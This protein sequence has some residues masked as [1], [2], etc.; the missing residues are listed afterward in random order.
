MRRVDRHTYVMRECE[1]GIVDHQRIDREVA[2][3]KRQNARVVVDGLAASSCIIFL[4]ALE[5]ADANLV[6]VTDN[7]WFLTHAFIRTD[8][9]GRAH[10]YGSES[11]PKPEPED[12][13][14]TIA[15][16]RCEIIRSWLRHN[17]HRLEYLRLSELPHTMMIALLGQCEDAKRWR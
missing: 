11:A 3:I 16:H 5:I 15:Q 1:G 13:T 4:E 12:L 17:R 14:Y 2:K 10:W 9:H 8:R 6:C 7:A